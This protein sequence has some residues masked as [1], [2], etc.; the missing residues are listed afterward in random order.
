METS[1]SRRAD[2]YM[3]S[4]VKARSFHAE[5]FFFFFRLLSDRPDF[6]S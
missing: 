5:D 2:R 1:L 3:V 6:G 4:R